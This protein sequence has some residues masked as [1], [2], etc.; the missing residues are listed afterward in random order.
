MKPRTTALFLLEQVLSVCAMG[1]ALFLSAGR[2]DWPAAWAAIAV[3]LGWFAAMD[4]I[5]LRSNP[6]LIA[7]RLSPPEGAKNWDRWILSFLR[8]A[9][10]GRYVLAGL[11]QRFGWTEGFPPWAQVA[12][13]FVCVLCTALYMWAL[14]SNPFF[15]QVV[16]V[17]RERG[18]AVASAGPYRYVRHPG[19]AG[20]VG[21]EVGISTLLGSWPAIARRRVL[22]AFADPAD[23]ARGPD[24][25]EGAGRVSEYAQR[26]RHRLVPGI[27]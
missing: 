9:E 24:A 1:A 25:E 7:E 22:R 16:R 2:T 4:I 13:L 27:W 17:Q 18:H 19:Y 15:S 8:L 6:E 26:V 12:A 21:F 11:D 14:A 10:L 23:R 5:L 20:M 3:W